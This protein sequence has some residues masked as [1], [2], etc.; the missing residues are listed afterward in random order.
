MSS[1]EFESESE[2]E[3]DHVDLV[4]ADNMRFFDEM[5][6]PGIDLENILAILKNKREVLMQERKVSKQK[7][8]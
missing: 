7:M 3:S 2:S 8:D 6:K 4:Q 1:E 5:Q